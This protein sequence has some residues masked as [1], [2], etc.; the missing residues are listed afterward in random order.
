[1]PAALRRRRRRFPRSN[2]DGHARLGLVTRFLPGPLVQGLHDLPGLRGPASPLPALTPTATRGPAGRA[3]HRNL[4]PGRHETGA[5]TAVAAAVPLDPR[6]HPGEAPARPAGGR[7]EGPSRWPARGGRRRHADLWQPRGPHP[8]RSPPQPLPPGGRP[9][10]QPHRCHT[11][12][13]LTTPMSHRC[14]PGRTRWPLARHR[15]AHQS[16]VAPVVSRRPG[17][18]LQSWQGPLSGLVWPWPHSRARPTPYPHCQSPWSLASC[19]VMPSTTAGYLS[20]HS[21]S[22]AMSASLALVTV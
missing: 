7:R 14:C 10:P 6:V 8:P 15:A 9:Q 21:F 1:M 19:S 18:T 12:V 2:Q 5:F 22:L 11:V 17:Q 3:A 16:T 4:R 20:R 13:A